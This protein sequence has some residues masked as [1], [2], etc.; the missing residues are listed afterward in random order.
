MPHHTNNSNNNF[1]NNS[2]NNSCGCDDSDSESE[3]S[4]SSFSNFRFHP[5]P[6]N[7]S[8]GKCG[9]NDES[10]VNSSSNSCGCENKDS[11]TSCKKSHSHSHSHSSSSSCSSPPRPSSPTP[12]P[13]ECQE[14]PNNPENLFLSKYV[15][16][17]K[18]CA[19]YTD[20]NEALKD[21]NCDPSNNTITIYLRPGTY[22]LSNE[23]STSKKI[24]IVGISPPSANMHGV[25]ITGKGCSG[26]NKGWQAVEFVG[27]CSTYNL[28][29]GNQ[30]KQASD[31][32]L[33][34][35][36][37]NNF[38]MKTVSDNFNVEN[39]E[40][41][42][43]GLDRKG[44]V[45][46]LGACAGSMV[47]TCSKFSICRT[48]CSKSNSFIHLSSN[49]TL[50][51][52]IFKD[53]IF[54]ASIDGKPDDNFSLFNIV[55]T[56][57][58]IFDNGIMD[59]SLANPKTYIFGNNKIVNNV[60]LYVSQSTF[61]G[62]NQDNLAL[63]ANLWSQNDP[64]KD[65]ITI[66]GCTVNKLR[67]MW[68]QDPQTT[69]KHPRFH[70]GETLLVSNAQILFDITLDDN[71]EFNITL[72][73][74]DIHST[75]N[76]SAMKLSQ[77]APFGSGNICNISTTFTAFNN[78]SGLNPPWLIKIIDTINLNPQGSSGLSGF[79]QSS[80]LLGPVPFLTLLIPIV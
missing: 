15:V 74:C 12:C 39:C 11:N 77:I 10:S 1:N 63:L 33:N 25:K 70:F 38:K 35:K 30:C 4:S 13:T 20:L 62:N 49:T 40:F 48:G 59:V 47:A 26:G 68:Y 32:F 5:N 27:K 60:N 22:Q 34:C 71:V 64:T 52:T 14:C 61:N 29:G 76:I 73:G 42:Y 28:N 36:F 7:S 80:T 19:N 44:G 65:P 41:N 17:E 54:N 78:G 6:S 46:E 56:Q 2:N 69:R 16:D 21:A 75:Y 55:G 51:R 58:I 66:K 57:Q 18:G 45:I 8:C 53:C 72:H 79:S 9:N 50:T 24:N 43:D 23:L 3:S 31:S 37:S 67:A